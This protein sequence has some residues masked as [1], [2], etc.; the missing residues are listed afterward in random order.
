M[1]PRVNI[2]RP[3]KP[4]REDFW[5]SLIG[6]LVHYTHHIN[7]ETYSPSY[8]N[9]HYLWGRLDSISRGEGNPSRSRKSLI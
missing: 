1:C 7:V 9:L 2:L 5:L 8:S 4:G 3:A 6:I